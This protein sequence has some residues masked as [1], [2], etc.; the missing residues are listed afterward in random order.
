[1]HATGGSASTHRTSWA[2][3]GAAVAV[4]LGAGGLGIVQATSPDG[5][6]TYVPITPCRLMDTR[7]GTGQVGV[8]VGPL[9]GPDAETTVEAW[10]DVAGDCNLPGD[11]RGLEL[12]VTA[13][14]ASQL[15]NL[16]FYPEGADTP[17]AS[18]LNPA[19]GAP[20][21]PN[22]VTVGLNS[23]NGRFHVFNRF[24]SVHVIIDVQ[25]YYTDHHHDDRYYTETEVDAAIDTAIEAYAA[26]GA[27]P[28]WGQ[29]VGSDDPTFNGSSGNVTVSSLDTGVYCLVVSERAA[30]VATQATP[31]NGHNIVT[32]A[33]GQA[34]VCDPLKVAGTS[35]VPVYIRTVGDVPVHANFVF[36][37][38]GD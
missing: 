35:V 33:T 23:T 7:P 36:Y 30:H 34:S 11:I 8:Q 19:P 9:V 22:A 18:N 2:A 26:A 10:G 20:P 5:A 17:T 12:N 6:S 21:T 32:V 28:A 15:T 1:M 3:I 4:S 31:S 29:V 16:R 14:D 25:G 27:E 24:G 37:I 38:P 13:T